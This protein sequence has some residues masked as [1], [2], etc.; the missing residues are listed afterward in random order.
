LEVKRRGVEQAI[1]DQFMKLKLSGSQQ[2]TAILTRLDQKRVAI[3]TR[4]VSGFMG[5][6]AL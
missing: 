2:A 4:R 5:Q 6:A 3:I 1:G